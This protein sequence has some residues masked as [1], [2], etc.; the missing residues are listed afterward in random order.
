MGAHVTFLDPVR[1]K[2]PQGGEVLCKANGS[3]DPRQPRGV[4]RPEDAEARAGC[5][6]EIDRTACGGKGEWEFQLTAERCRLARTRC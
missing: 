3:G 1:H 5:G 6:V 4:R 2:R